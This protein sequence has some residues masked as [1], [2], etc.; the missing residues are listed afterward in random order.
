MACQVQMPAQVQ[1]TPP[2]A[3]QFRTNC[4][5]DPVS[6]EH[7]EGIRPAPAFSIRNE[8]GHLSRRRPRQTS[9]LHENAAPASIK[10][11]QVRPIQLAIF[12]KVQTE[13]FD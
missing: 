1:P 3:A 12:H 13:I 9:K 6:D 10:Q 7:M 11:D 2:V 5:G 4:L 8:A